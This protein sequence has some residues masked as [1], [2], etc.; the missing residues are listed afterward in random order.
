VVPIFR[1][2]DENEAP[3]SKPR[4]I[5]SPL[6]DSKTIIGLKEIAIRMALGASRKE[7]IKQ[8]V[9]ESLLISFIL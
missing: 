1:R 6:R 7:I 3:R 8:L 9:T 5:A 2:Y 4:G